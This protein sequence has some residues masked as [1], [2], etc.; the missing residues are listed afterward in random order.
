MA[1]IAAQDNLISNAHPV[2]AGTL[3]VLLA[4]SV[5]A[6]RG[7]LR[8]AVT[9]A[10]GGIGNPFVSALEDATSAV[11]TVLAVVVPVPAMLTVI[12]IA[13][14]AAMLRRWRR[15]RRELRV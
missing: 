11:V 2:L 14:W 5:R 13:V 12:G 10:T 6:A 3:G 15:R 1:V 7:A 8:P 4:G 9:A